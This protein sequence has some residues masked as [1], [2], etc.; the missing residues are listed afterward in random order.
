MCRLW[1]C[2]IC[3]VWPCRTAVGEKHYHFALFS[4]YFE[5]L[6]RTMGDHIVSFCCLT[7]WRARCYLIARVRPYMSSYQN[8]ASLSNRYDVT[9]Y[10][11]NLVCWRE[12]EKGYL[13]DATRQSW[14]RVTGHLVTGSVIMSGSGRVS[15]QSYLLQT[16]YCDPVADRTTEWYSMVNTWI[17]ALC[18]VE[19]QWTR[20]RWT[21]N[22]VGLV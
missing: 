13:K 17:N 10:G 21:W 7:D 6:L 19:A 9:V 3:T 22:T 1:T 4:N 18:K 8:V 14:N 2:N 11:W 16:R 5:D 20:I 12:S 15:G